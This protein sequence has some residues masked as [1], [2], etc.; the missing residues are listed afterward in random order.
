M[1]AF[2]YTAFRGQAKEKSWTRALQRV[3]EMGLFATC[4]KPHGRLAE[5]MERAARL[6]GKIKC[7]AK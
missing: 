1:S 3:K 7:L 5:F 6:P 2:V 4:V